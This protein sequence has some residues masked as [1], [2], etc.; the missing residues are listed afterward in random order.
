MFARFRLEAAVGCMLLLTF[1]ALLGERWILKTVRV[2]DPSSGYGVFV[3]DD[4]SSGGRSV[5][6][7][8]ERSPTWEWQCTL[9]EG[10]SQPFCGFEVIFDPLRQQGLDLS[11]VKEVRLWL[12]YEGESPYLRIFLRNHNPA[13]SSPERYDSTKF[14]QVEVKAET[15]EGVLELSTADFFVANWWITM[16]GIP[17]ELSHPEITNVV[18]LEV[19]TATNPPLG[20]HKFHL[21]RIEFIEQ[22]ITTLQWYQ[23]LFGLWLAVAVVFFVTRMFQLKREVTQRRRREKELVAVNKLLDS[24]GRELE[25]KVKRDPLT[26]AY[27][28]QGIER[29]L[30]SGLSAR[31]QR[32]V[33]MT[34][35]LLDI[36]HFKSINDTYGHLAGDNVLVK[37]SEL[38]KSNIRQQ[39]AFARWGGEEF[40]LVCQNTSIDEGKQLAEKLRKLVEAHPFDEDIHVTVSMG[41]AT[42]ANNETITRFFER[43]DEALYAAKTGGRNRVA[44]S[45]NNS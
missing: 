38:I 14:N 44:V 13:Y 20:E 40:L 9:N 17:P 26:G 29:A 15:V 1:V 32:G 4:R 12:E 33:P 19:N 11:S 42:L 16:N 21:R 2:I 24:R 10:H 31:R 23:L 34:L 5:G 28:R 30:E 39:D 22:R 27:N 8:L 18:V 43:A 35:I 41:V 6:R 7:I 37:L 36:D 3:Y 25:N 45:A